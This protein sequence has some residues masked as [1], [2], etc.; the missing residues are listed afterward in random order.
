MQD[1]LNFFNSSMPVGYVLAA[2]IAA[3]VAWKAGLSAFN[4]VKGAMSNFAPG[5]IAA[6]LMFATG[7]GGI[8]Y[9]VGDLV[10]RNGDDA[11][12]EQA[13]EVQW[14]S[15]DEILSLRDADDDNLRQLLQF[16]KDQTERQR[17]FLVER[18]SAI[19]EKELALVPTSAEGEALAAVDFTLLGAD[20]PTAAVDTSVTEDASVVDR[21]QLPIQGTI[22]L[23]GACIA[24]LIS[25]VVTFIRQQA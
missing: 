12:A 24:V 9:S 21:P 4:G 5:S 16:A 19:A 8:G 18:E 20:D 2:A 17:T 13:A 11:K 1:V 7:I 23:L 6:A 10:S 3:F 15:N 14:L 25:G 22:G